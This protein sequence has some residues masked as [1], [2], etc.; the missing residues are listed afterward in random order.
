MF[1]TFVNVIKVS[2]K[3]ADSKLQ[4]AISSIL[5]SRSFGQSLYQTNVGTVTKPVLLELP[6]DK[7]QCIWVF[8]SAWM[9]IYSSCTELSRADL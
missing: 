1:D 3:E 7:V 9:Y 8:L 6:R 2:R 5:S 4:A